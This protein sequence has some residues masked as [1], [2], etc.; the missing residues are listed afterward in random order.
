M[1]NTTNTLVTT[2]S[3]LAECGIRPVDRVMGEFSLTLSRS[4]IKLPVILEIVGNPEHRTDEES[5]LTLGHVF[6]QLATF[7]ISQDMDSAYSKFRVIETIARKV[8]EVYGRK[9]ASITPPAVNIDIWPNKSVLYLEYKP[10]KSTRELNCLVQTASVIM[11]TYSKLQVQCYVE[12]VAGGIQQ[13]CGMVASFAE[14]N[15]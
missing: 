9:L 15:M 14:K 12:A 10:I 8:T 5:L 11:A 4:D 3:D 2:L 6:I 7:E 13:N 1:E